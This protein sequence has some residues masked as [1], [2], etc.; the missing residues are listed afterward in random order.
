VTSIGHEAFSG[1]I[2]LIYNEYN[3]G[4]YLGNT[5]KPYIVLIK[6]KNKSITSCKINDTTKFIL[7]SAFSDC[8]S[9]TSVEIGDSVTSIGSYAFS[10]CYSLTSI[11]YCGTEDEW[12]NIS[13]NSD[14]DYGAESYT[15][16]YNYV[17]EEATENDYGLEYTL[18]ED[19]SSYSV[20]G[21]GKCKATDIVIPKK[22]KGLPVTSIGDDAFYDCD[23]LT[24]VVIGDSVTSIGYAAFSNCTSLTSVEIG[25]SVTSIG[26]YAF[27][28]CCSLKSVEIGDSVTSIGAWTFDNCRSLTSVT[29]KNP[30][31][32]Q[33]D[34]S[35]IFSSN[36][37][38][39]STAA[40]YLTYT[41]V[42]YN[43]HRS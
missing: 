36:L 26:E 42:S 5:S 31:G 10:N 12:N 8:T 21:I 33:A 43:W 16:T 39:A 3:N 11:K 34:G 29:F 27:S 14:W 15:I 22:Y 40:R 4:L 13:K 30:N 19:Q 6:A 17:S 18:N 38:Y 7:S 32:W 24:S 1:C 9:L 28:G 2:N 25:D 37:A 20:T 41:Y 23:S 35:G